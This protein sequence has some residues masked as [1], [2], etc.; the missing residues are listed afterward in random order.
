MLQVWGLESSTEL[1]LDHGASSSGNSG[2][3]QQ[4]P[5][6]RE[7]AASKGVGVGS[8]NPGVERGMNFLPRTV[9]T[10]DGPLHVYS[11]RDD[12]KQAHPS[13]RQR[14]GR[15][16]QPRRQRMA[17]SGGD[18][19]YG[20]I[21]GSG[22]SGSSRSS[23]NGVDGSGGGVS[24]S[25]GSGGGA[26]LGVGLVGGLG[27]R[28]TFEQMWQVLIEE[29]MQQQAPLHD[30]E[31]LDL[32]EQEQEQEGAGRGG[33]WGLGLRGSA[34]VGGRRAARPQPGPEPGLSQPWSQLQQ[35]QQQQGQGQGQGQRHQQEEQKE[36]EE[37]QQEATGQPYVVV[38]CATRVWLSAGG[39]KAWHQG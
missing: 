15:T 34:R 22:V 2:Q 25:G 7:G 16:H 38:R 19:G 10:R 23:S 1:Q 28:Q 39:I 32:A 20:N 36:Q 30:W 26:G 8:V 29:M 12:T 11:Y 17:G 24:G 35:W 9:I 37:E 3:Q 21:S 13:S 5:R 31:D 33:V 4:Q 14:S 18:G 6:G 27:R